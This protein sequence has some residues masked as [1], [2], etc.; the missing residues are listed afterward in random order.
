M[1]KIK[2]TNILPLVAALAIGALITTQPAM[3]AIDVT[4]ATDVI[5]TDGTTA[6]TAVGTALISLAGLAVVFR[7]I[8]GSIFG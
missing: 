8:K 1:N 3:A 4:G 5:S 7:W 2:K 6:I